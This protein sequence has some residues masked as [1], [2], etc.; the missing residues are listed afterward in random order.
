M[1]FNSIYKI[2]G[3]AMGSALNA[4]STLAKLGNRKL[5]IRLLPKLSK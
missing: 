4:V 3:S 2:A 1:A 5:F